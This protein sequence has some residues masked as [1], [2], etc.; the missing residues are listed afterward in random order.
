LPLVTIVSV[1]VG[2]LIGGTVIVEQ[3]FGL[4]G[5]GSLLINSITTRD[6]AIIQLVTL[7]LA[8]VV[9]SVNLITDLLYAGLDPRVS[10][11]A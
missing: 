5:L 11:R 10:L 4:P 8:G 1:N 9:I 7:I 6:Y 3:I 2:W